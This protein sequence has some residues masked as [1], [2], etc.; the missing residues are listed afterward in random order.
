MIGKYAS[1]AMSTVCS[2]AM[3]KMVYAYIHIAM[4]EWLI[5]SS[6]MYLICTSYMQLL[7][8]GKKFSYFQISDS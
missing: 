2:Y 5:V 4:H 1:S 7:K 3:K 8:M 6:Y